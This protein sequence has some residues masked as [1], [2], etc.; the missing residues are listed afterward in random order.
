MI[1]EGNAQA[2]AVG[3]FNGMLGGGEAV[4]VG[5]GGVGEGPVPGNFEPEFAPDPDDNGTVKLDGVGDGYWP[6]GR[7]FYTAVAVDPSAKVAAGLIYLEIS[8]PDP[9][10]ASSAAPTPTAKVCGTSGALP[11]PTDAKSF[12]PLYAIYGGRISTD[13]RSCMSL[14]MREL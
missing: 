8:H 7:H 13:F 6:F 14:T 3:F 12:I 9:S 2:S 11:L 10:S 5:G 1:D 4:G